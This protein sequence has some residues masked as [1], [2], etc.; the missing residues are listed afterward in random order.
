MQSLPRI[1]TKQI[2][3]AKYE[4]KAA[5]LNFNSIDSILIILLRHILIC[6]INCPDINIRVWI[7]EDQIH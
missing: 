7:S 4:H 2:Y 1:Y 3:A 5:N 6:S